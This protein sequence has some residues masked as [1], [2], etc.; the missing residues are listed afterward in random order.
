MPK[1][2]T[3]ENDRL[4]VDRN[5][6]GHCSVH[7]VAHDAMV[8]TARRDDHRGCS[9]I[10]ALF[11]ITLVGG[12]IVRFMHI[13]A[14]D[15]YYL[16]GPDSYWF[17]QQVD[18]LRSGAT[19][20]FIKSGLIYP[21]AY[22]PWSD[23]WLPVAVYAVSAVLVYLY[24][25]HIWG[26]WPAVSA[27]ACWT[28]IPEIVLVSSAGWIDRDMVV[29]VMVSAIG[30]MYITWPGRWYTLVTV[31]GLMVAVSIIWTPFASLVIAGLTGILLLGRFAVYRTIKL[32]APVVIYVA[33]LIT[34]VIVILSVG[35]ID[36][37]GHTLS[38]HGGYS[39]GYAETESIS[40]GSLFT[41]YGMFLPLV[42]IGIYQGLKSRGL[43]QM[44]LAIWLAAV[45]M[46]SIMAQ[47]L[48]L[49]AIFPAAV[50]SGM[51]IYRAV[52]YVQESTIRKIDKKR[53][54]AILVA[55]IAVLITS[56][57]IQ[58]WKIGDLR[59][60]APDRY[61]VDACDWLHQ[62]DPCTVASH[63]NFES[64][65]RDLSEQDTV[66]CDKYYCSGAD[67]VIAPID[68]DIPLPIVYKNEGVVIYADI[69]L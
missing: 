53:V 64:W 39:T 59:H 31:I 11:L 42:I 60:I 34:A 65:T 35:S 63:W 9:I 6:R 58:A 61:W 54:T 37:I 56:S 43:L 27:M 1:I 48:M 46:A 4:D 57:F 12:I 49:F 52:M 20:P 68:A 8:G 40:L 23:Y 51:L 32:K 30:A 41:G 24:V 3:F 66:S 19:V 25:R 69:S 5:N 62:Q 33:M 10:R 14:G 44:Q 36:G 47:R 7:A 38:R 17:H 55:G 15:H 21:I 18:N 28:F 2:R 45:L 16:L 13:F 26:P 29:G 67:Y 22:M 50:L